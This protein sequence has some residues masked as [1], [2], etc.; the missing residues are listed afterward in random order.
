VAQTPAGAT[1]AQ[2]DCD[3][4]TTAVL[5]MCGVLKPGRRLREL[6]LTVGCLLAT[7]REAGLAGATLAQADCDGDT[8]AVL[9]MCGVLKLGRCL[10]ELVLT[11]GCLSAKQRI[12]CSI[13]TFRME[14]G[15]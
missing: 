13:L 1:L 2:A 15:R 10:R 9:V 8:T 11:V 14:G 5:V 7:Q 3:G 4:D 6:V 12:C